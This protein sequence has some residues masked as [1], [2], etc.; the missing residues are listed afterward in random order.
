MTI[1]SCWIYPVVRRPSTIC[2]ILSF[3]WRYS[4]PICQ[5]Q[6]HLLFTRCSV[7]ELWG[8]HRS[9]DSKK[10]RQNNGQKKKGPKNYLQSTTQKSKDR[11]TRTPHTT[12]DER[13]CSRKIRSSCPTSGTHRVTL[14]QHDWENGGINIMTKGIYQ[15][16]FVTMI[17]HNS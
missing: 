12:R 13:M 5:S 7:F 2:Y 3:H 1:G 16:L 14:V 11:A 6:N 4:A 10:E 15:W 8:Y 9:C 17:F